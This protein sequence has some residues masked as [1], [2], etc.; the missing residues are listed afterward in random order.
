MKKVPFVKSI[1][2]KLAFIVV[3]G[4]IVGAVI[5]ELILLIVNNLGFFSEGLM[6]ITNFLVNLLTI[7]AIIVIFAQLFIIN[8]IHKVN[9]IIYEINNGNFDVEATDRW[10]DELTFLNENVVT[11]GNNISTLINSVKNEADEVNKQSMSV[12]ES[13]ET[14]MSLQHQ[15]KDIFDAYNESEQ[16]VVRMFKSTREVLEEVSTGL[17]NGTQHIQGVS[18]KSAEVSEH[19]TNTQ[20][21][22]EKMFNTIKQLERDSFETSKLVRSLSD[23][24]KEIVAVVN[25]IE[26]I[27]NQTN[28]LA[29]NAAIEAARAGE[30]GKGFAVVAAEVRKLAENSV[31][32]TERISSIINAIQ[33]EVEHVVISIDKD[34]QD[35]KESEVLFETSHEHI[36]KIL[37]EVQDITG[38]IDEVAGAIEEITASSQEIGSAIDMSKSI[39]VNN[40]AKLTE[41]NDLKEK[42]VQSTLSRKQDID[43]LRGTFQS[44]KESIDDIAK[45]K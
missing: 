17:D 9:A 4:S 24:T 3:I 39:M 34:R 44:L 2:F 40:Q 41:L 8:R 18:M 6:V 28:L 38:D 22:L 16:E 11:V 21:I 33:E 15:L 25:V 43:Y 30:H 14:L 19:G 35:V 13:F 26:G 20:A 29:L 42:M 37:A 10:G 5:S 12:S 7:P 23:R 27:S 31:R 45:T 36:N 1:L 32:E